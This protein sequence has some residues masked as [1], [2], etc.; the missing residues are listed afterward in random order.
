[1]NKQNTYTTIHINKAPHEQWYVQ[2]PIEAL[3]Q[4]ARDL[5]P[6]EFK[7]YLMLSENADGYY[8]HAGPAMFREKMG[9]SGTDSFKK[10]LN[11]LVSKGYCV[12]QGFAFYNESICSF[13]YE[14][15][16]FP[17]KE[18]SHE[19]R[20]EEYKYIIWIHSL[21]D[22]L[23][24]FFD[25][26]T[27]ENERLSYNQQG[28]SNKDIFYALYYWYIEL[29]RDPAPSKGHLG[30]VSSVVSDAKDFFRLKRAFP[31]WD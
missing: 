4:A 6:N 15:Y 2:F 24:Y 27:I 30:I 10:A 19:V 29:Q 17:R 14:F 31:T 26:D 25:Y 5:K 16:Q 9:A 11:G 18:E 23:E 7:L 28:I 20:T 1:M 8:L 12:R 21:L 22:S 3:N 13:P